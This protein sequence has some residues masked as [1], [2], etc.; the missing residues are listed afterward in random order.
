M[1]FRDIR[2]FNKAL[3][4]KQ[5]WRMLTNPSSL[6]AR[7]FVARYCRSGDFLSA[8]VPA[9]ASF[10]W[11]SLVWSRDLVSSGLA[12]RIGNGEEV[13][14]YDDNWVMGLHGNLRK[15]G[16]SVRYDDLGVKD[17]IV[18]GSRWN[19]AQVHNLFS[20]IVQA[21]ILATPI[22]EVGDRDERF[23]RFDV[24]GR[25]SVKSAYLAAIGFYEAPDNMSEADRK[26]WSSLVWN[27]PIPP[28]ARVFGWRAFNN[29]IPTA[30][31]LRSHHVPVDGICSLCGDRWA[32]TEHSLLFCPRIVSVWKASRFWRV[33]KCAKGLSLRDIA[34][35]VRGEFGGDDHALWM[36]LLWQ[37]WTFICRSPHSLT[38]E[39]GLISES[40]SSALQ[41]PAPTMAK[42]DSLGIVLGD[43]K[44]RKPNWNTLRMDVDAYFDPIGHRF[45]VGVVVRDQD[46]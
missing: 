46:G 12:W 3:L 9:N 10:I 13:S 42:E 20:P 24:E 21:S 16:E 44:W 17:L 2:S 35:A 19:E 39:A 23:W 11:R 15:C 26:S 37:V 29:L 43:K 25:F 5:L 38:K 27:V 28:K 30:A 6:V 34:V 33:L 18:S 41:S 40:S 8:P 7:A 31:N 45:G 14:M 36:T 32:S 22:S 4:A 1:G